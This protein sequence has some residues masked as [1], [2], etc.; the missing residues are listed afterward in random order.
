L[1]CWNVIDEPGIISKELSDEQLDGLR[2]KE[3][4][5]CLLIN[6]PFIEK[7]CNSPID[8]YSGQYVPD[9]LVEQLHIRIITFAIIDR[10][11]K[12]AVTSELQMLLFLI[13]IIFSEVIKS[14]PY[15]VPHCIIT[16]VESC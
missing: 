8:A 12:L 7:S 13:S 16:E 15:P 4:R 1:G 5:A 6:S 2:I 3:M 9:V 14:L 11:F 10:A